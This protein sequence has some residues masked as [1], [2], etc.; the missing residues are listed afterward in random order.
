[1]V[2]GFPE[3]SSSRRGLS[4]GMVKLLAHS[5]VELMNLWFTTRGDGPGVSSGHRKAQLYREQ[6]ENAPFDCVCERRFQKNR[7]E[8][9]MKL[10]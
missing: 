3:I 9:K 7:A 8:I 6:G 5:N 1:M 4:K 2:T 10:F